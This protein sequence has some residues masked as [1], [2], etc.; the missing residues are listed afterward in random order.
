MKLLLI[1]KRAQLAFFPIKPALFGKLS[2]NRKH[3]RDCQ[4]LWLFLLRPS[5]SLFFLTLFKI[6]DRNHPLVFRL[7]QVPDYSFLR[8]TATAEKLT[9]SC[10]LFWPS[11]VPCCFFALTSN[12]RLL[13]HQQFLPQLSSEKPVR[14][15]CVLSRHYCN[16]HT[17]FYLLLISPELAKFKAFVRHLRLSDPVRFLFCLVDCSV[18]SNLETSSSFNKAI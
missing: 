18:R 11:T 13:S 7:Q 4:F 8:S 9:K 10:A 3:Q 15:R 5:H 14:S 12:W 6:S 16:A 1:L 17:A 2:A